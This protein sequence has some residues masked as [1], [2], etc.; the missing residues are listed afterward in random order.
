MQGP[1]DHPPIEDVGGK[2]TKERMGI[3]LAGISRRL[4]FMQKKIERHH[5]EGQPMSLVGPGE[6]D[7]SDRE[8]EELFFAVRKFSPAMK[9]MD[10]LLTRILNKD[11]KI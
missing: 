9:E 11:G 5:V 1:G 3:I 4:S 8:L 2:L 10:D 7:L 6:A